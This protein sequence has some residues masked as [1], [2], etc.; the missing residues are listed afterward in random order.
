MYLG[1]IADLEASRAAI[2]IIL[3]NGKMHK[4]DFRHSYK[5]NLNPS[6]GAGDTRATGASGAAMGFPR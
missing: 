1:N 6:R 4:S 5:L 3:Q 2:M